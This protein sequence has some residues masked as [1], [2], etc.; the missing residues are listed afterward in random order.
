MWLLVLFLLF[1]IRSVFSHEA[2][3]KSTSIPLTAYLHVGPHKTGSTHLQMLMI[4]EKKESFEKAGFCFP[5]P[6]NST[7]GHKGFS[8]LP[9]DLLKD[10]P[11]TPSILT[12]A[13]KC[14]ARSSSI[15]ISAEDLSR[16][17]LSQIQLLKDELS[18]LV[19]SNMTLQFKVV[20]FLREYMSRYYSLFAELLK[21]GDQFQGLGITFS[22]YLSHTFDKVPYSPINTLLL[23]QN[24]AQVF[25]KE[26]LVLIDYDGVNAAK[27]DL[28]YV[29]VCKI[30]NV[31]CNQQDLIKERRNQR[32]SAPYLHLTYLIRFYVTTRNHQICHFNYTFISDNVQYY[33]NQS[34][35]L[36]LIRSNLTFL[37][38]YSKALDYSI[39]QEFRS[40]I[41]YGNEA[42]VH[43][44]I[45][46]FYIEEINDQV[47][48]NDYHWMKFQHS[49]YERLRKAEKLCP[50]ER[51]HLRK[52]DFWS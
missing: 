6:P 30:L 22:R 50:M 33:Q 18:R 24:Y 46:E 11:P 44:V 42:A 4:D 8:Y 23:A 49:E 19:P 43:K 5:L 48:Y 31:S 9:F 36:P 10:Q 25:G 16:L 2:N 28:A 12:E 14:F 17:K 35:H 51:Y 29:F 34:I 47:F 7:A 40:N 20:I 15:I 1:F 38:N 3:G 37:H 39:R 52:T 26:N 13:K 41:L 27:V 32:M 45:D 21:M